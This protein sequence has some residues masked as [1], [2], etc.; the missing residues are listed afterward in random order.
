MSDQIETDSFSQEITTKR[1]AVLFLL[2]LALFIAFARFHTYYEPVEHDI[3]TASVIANEMRHGRRYY[4]EVWENKPPAVHIANL[5]A[6]VI[7]GYN[8]ASIYALN[9]FLSIA[10][11]LGVYVAA[12]GS[13]MGRA[14]GLWAAI[15]WTLLSGDVSLQANQ[16]NLEAFMNGPLIWAFAL[17]LRTRRSGNG[18]DKSYILWSLGIGALIALASFYKPQCAFYGFFFAIAHIAFPPAEGGRKQAI[19]EVLLIG[20]VGALAWI[21][22]F[23]YFAATGRFQILYITMFEYP[24]YYT[25][26]MFRN[27]YNSLRFSALYPNEIKII[28]PLIFLTFV[29]GVIAFAKKSLRPWIVLAAYLVA[30]QVEIGISGRFYNHYYQL[31][32]PIFCVGAGWA[33]IMLG[34]IIKETLPSWLPHAFAA[35]ALIFILQAEL[36]VF[37]MN[38]EQF[39]VQSYGGFY[40][41]SEGVAREI[42][43]ILAP[44]ETLFVLGDEPAFYFHTGRR[45]A[46]GSFFIADMA[47]GPL[48]KELT[49][50]AIR[51]LERQPPDMVIILNYAIGDR[52]LGPIDARLGPTH[53]LRMWISQHYCPVQINRVALLSICVRPGSGIETR[54]E[55]Q[56]MMTELNLIN[57]R[58]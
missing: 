18:S 42:N 52:N 54:P 35:V 58:K 22:Y 4:S 2:G 57:E 40:A 7:F 38:P 31:W 55:Y 37:A 48:A 47:D 45:P 34:G 32:L 27:L 8:R 25:G 43:K 30:T 51:D 16:P 49:D 46:V 33:V 29:G 24:K 36:G 26:N 20:A 6:Q 1:F 44:N 9:V 13:G 15:F 23:A 21:A 50:R 19:K 39:S 28:A 3:T 53:P 5:I 12:S 41:A 11:L 14:G 17:L 56:T 10:T